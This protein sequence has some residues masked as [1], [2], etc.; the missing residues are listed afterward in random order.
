VV[1]VP[2]PN[3]CYRGRRKTVTK[4]EV[5]A[6]CASVSALP[7]CQ[8]Q[9]ADGHLLTLTHREYDYEM[10]RD[11]PWTMPDGEEAWYDDGASE[12]LQKDWYEAAHAARRA[13]RGWESAHRSKIP[14]WAKKF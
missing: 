7:F 10:M 12:E 11:R 13:V 6:L 8:L 5:I 1:A 14:Q 3:E 4:N 9:N 2:Q